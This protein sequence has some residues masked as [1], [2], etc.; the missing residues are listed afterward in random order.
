MVKILLNSLVCASEKPMN[1]RNFPQSF[2]NP[3]A[4]QLKQQVQLEHAQ[5]FPVQTRPIPRSLFNGHVQVGSLGNRIYPS[6]WHPAS[7]DHAVQRRNPNFNVGCIRVA[8]PSSHSV[9]NDT[10]SGHLGARSDIMTGAANCYGP[11]IGYG[12][13]PRYNSLLVQPDVS[14][15]LPRIPGEP[16]SS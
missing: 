9:N 11:R 14:P 4:R 8:A 12:F 10:F 16:R 2:W 15:Q 3:D 7:S 6:Q 5:S 13:N 1:E